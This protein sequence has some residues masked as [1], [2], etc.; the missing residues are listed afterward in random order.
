MAMIFVSA[1]KQK[2]HAANSR[3]SAVAFMAYIAG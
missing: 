3:N 2:R 1:A